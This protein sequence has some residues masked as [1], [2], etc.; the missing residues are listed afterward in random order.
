MNLLDAFFVCGPGCV[1][2]RTTPVF[3]VRIGT[4]AGRM[5]REEAAAEVQ[6]QGNFPADNIFL[7]MRSFSGL[8]FGQAV[9]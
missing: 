4:V 9:Y 6:T 7:S 2:A 5:G 1:A 3:E 8:T